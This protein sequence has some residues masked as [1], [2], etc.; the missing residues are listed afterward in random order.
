MSLGVSTDYLALKRVLCRKSLFEFVKRFWDVIIEE[1]PEWNWHISFLCDEV[2]KTME[3]VFLS[4]PKLYDLIIN[5]SPGETKSTLVS[6]CLTPWAW[7]RMPSFRSI[8]G[9]YAADLSLEMSRKARDIVESDEYRECFPEVAIRKD[10]NTK[11]NFVTTSKG[12]RITTSTGAGITGK[13]AHALIIDDP[14]NPKQA[15]SDAELKEANMWM[16][17]TLSSRKVNKTVTPTILIMQRLAQND[18]TGS[19]LSKCKKEGGKGVRHICLPATDDYPIK[20]KRL[21]R[22]YVNG[23]MNPIRTTR[24]VLEEVKM[25]SG[26]FVLSCQYGQSPIPRGGGM[27]KR[28]R[29]KIVRSLPIEGFKRVVRYWDKA[30]SHDSGCWTVGA[31]IAHQEIKLPGSVVANRFWLLD[32]VRFR[33]A[34]E[35]REQIILNTAQSDGVDIH[36]ALEQEGGSGGK[37]QIYA[38]ISN[39]AG[40]RVRA[41]RPVGDKVVRADPAAVQWN[42][43]NFCMI[44][45]SWNEIFLDELQYFPY[46]TFKDQ[47]DALSGAFAYLMAPRM[48]I[49]AFR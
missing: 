6:V 7:T 24:A 35:A 26:D 10:Q 15:S 21:Q 48:K 32:V 29:V 38:S 28:D 31:K 39:L 27:F 42:N 45:A 19:R 36:V 49:G 40:F 30:G 23:L 9:S 25:V 16:E 46:S 14:L 2:Q 44:E 37:D 11:S 22:N 17:E 5:I 13:H 47:V 4:Q 33:E 34:V 3:R 41:D 43:Y 8:N 1:E 18:P 20:P 12:Q